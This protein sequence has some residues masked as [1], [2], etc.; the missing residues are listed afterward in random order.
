MA[1]S[2]NNLITATIGYGDLVTG[3]FTPSDNSLLVAVVHG[4][5]ENIATDAGSASLSGGGL[6]WTKRV[7]QYQVDLQYSPGGSYVAIWTAPV[8]TGASMTLTHTKSTPGSYGHAIAV[9]EYTGYNTTSPTGAT[10]TTARQHTE[11]ALSGTL[12]AA[13]ASDSEVIAGVSVDNWNRSTGVITTGTGWTQQNYFEYIES[14]L[15]AQVQTRTSSTSTSVGWNFVD[16]DINGFNG[17]TDVSAALEIKAAAAASTRPK[18]IKII[19][20]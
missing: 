11:G 17:G 12:S 3:S 4:S 18:I 14:S 20:M 16:G 8:S 13:P 2:R 19:T 7:E 10:A 5:F 6:T 9:Y 1:L 15:H